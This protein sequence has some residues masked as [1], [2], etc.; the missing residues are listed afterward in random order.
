MSAPSLTLYVEYG[1]R[2]PGHRRLIDTLS[3]LGLIGTEL[4]SNVFLAGPGF[5][6]RVSFLGC[7]PRLHLDPD[8][9]DD[10]LHIQVPEL[11]RPT[12]RAARSGGSPLCPDCRQPISDWR[13][14]AETL[15][16][17]KIR[18]VD[19]ARSYPLAAINL[20]KRACVSQCIVNITPVYES[21]AVPSDGL[22]ESLNSALDCR[23]AY[24]YTDTELTTNRE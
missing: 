17:G 5:F 9:S 1:D 21:E 18:C 19:C 13:N 7:S 11:L 14:Q 8:N 20:R 6:N 23:F 16:G 15:A 24:A 12:V 10:F 3:T 2:V 22:L 4:D